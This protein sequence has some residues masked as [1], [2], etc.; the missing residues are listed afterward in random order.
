MRSQPRT[1]PPVGTF[2]E[3]GGVQL[4]TDLRGS[5]SPTIV[6]LPGAG[7]AALDYLA[8]H[9]KASERWTS[10]LYDRAG[11]GYSEHVPLPRTAKAV[12]DELHEL[13]GK[14]GAELVLLVGHSLGGL[15]A[16]HYATRFAD[17]VAGLVLLDPAHE[18][19]NT[20]MP[21]ELVN[22]RARNRTFALLNRLV[23]V[24]MSTRPTKALLGLLPP[25]RHYQRLYA[26]LFD[27]AFAGWPPDVRAALVARHC[28][29]D[30]L[31]VGLQEARQLDHLYAEVRSVGP[32]PDIPLI[33]LSSTTTDAF[34][35]AVSVGEPPDLMQ[36]EFA[37]KAR[38]YEQFS[39][40][41]SS[42][43]CDPS[44][45][46]TSQWPFAIPKQSWRQWARSRAAHVATM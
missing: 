13:L 36:A 41:V 35:D 37:G 26:R 21:A 9:E 17:S 45:W 22:A 12:T 16:R 28:S 43:R 31:A 4:F 3:V 46:V 2:L 33:I 38:L 18:D 29:L 23:D 44:T 25:V 42:A 40:G 1:V 6:F 14:L 27:E 8:L 30:W 32:V 34:R 20:Y 11:T 39:Q 5:G 10:V 19:Y 15:Y 24:A 7:A